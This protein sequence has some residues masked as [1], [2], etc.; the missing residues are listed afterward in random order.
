MSLLQFLFPG[1]IFSRKPK[2]ARVKRVLEKRAPKLVE[3]P[4]RAIFVRSSTANAVTQSILHDLVTPSSMK[5]IKFLLKKPNATNF[6]KKNEIRPFEDA[7]SLEFFAEKEDASL[8]VV[9]S[10]SKKRPNNLT[11]ARMFDHKLLDMVELGVSNYKPC[12]EFKVIF[13]CSVTY[14]ESRKY[15]RV[16]A[17]DGILW[18]CIRYASSI[19]PFQNFDDGLFQRADSG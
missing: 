12:L 8:F 4:K 14:A 7:S 9:G 1:L 19:F 5:L 3:N 18:A 6:S 13:L 16:E 11:F 10:H 15:S 17:V 2:N